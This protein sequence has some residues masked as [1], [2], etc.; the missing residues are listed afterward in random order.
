M[1]E[2]GAGLSAGAGAGT[3]GHS[4]LYILII[5]RKL[6]TNLKSL[7]GVEPFL[8]ISTFLKPYQYIEC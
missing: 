6:R 3:A 4:G 5:L 2:K 8:N 1:G 7:V